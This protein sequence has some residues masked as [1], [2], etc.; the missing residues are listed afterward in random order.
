MGGASRAG[1]LRGS[2][3]HREASRALIH[4]QPTGVHLSYTSRP[5]SVLGGH[6]SSVASSSRCSVIW[7]GIAGEGLVADFPGGKR[8]LAAVGEGGGARRSRRSI[9]FRFAFS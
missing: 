4:Y 7:F 2:N 3:S 5:L 6:V 9:R 8:A 1:H